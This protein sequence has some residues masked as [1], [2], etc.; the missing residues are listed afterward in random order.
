MIKK[1]LLFVIL[2]FAA[3]LVLPFAGCMNQPSNGGGGGGTTYV[4]NYT[5]A[6]NGNGSTGGSVPDD[7]N[8]YTNGQVV[9]VLGNTGSLVNTGFTFLCWNTQANDSG[10]TYYPGQ[11]FVMGTSSI[12]LY[13]QWTSLYTVTYYGNGNFRRDHSC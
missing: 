8:N 1:C 4:S 12:I 13:A 3:A 2:A 6:Y 9:T 7:T 11:T 5:V 10:T